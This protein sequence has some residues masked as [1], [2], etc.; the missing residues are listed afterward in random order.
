VT[1]NA[2][3]YLSI[4]IRRAAAWNQ[5]VC[6]FLEFEGA[7]Y[8]L[9]WLLLLSGGHHTL[10]KAKCRRNVAYQRPCCHHCALSIG[11]WSS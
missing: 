7:C 10:Q 6:T 11:W 8:Q 2:Y 3:V 1:L 4:I 9:W 5:V